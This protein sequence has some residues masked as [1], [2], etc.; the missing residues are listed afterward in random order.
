M[1]FL[2]ILGLLIVG[3]FFGRMRRNRLEN[4]GEGA[5]RRYLTT[6]FP[7]DDFHLMNNLTLPYGDGTTQID[8]VLVSRYGVFVVETKHW[9]GW[10]FA[11]A[12]AAKWTQVKFKAKR[13]F[14]NP[15][16][17]NH[18]HVLAVRALLDFVRAE[19][20]HSVVV[21][22]GDAVFKTNKPPGV[23][24]CRE[25][26]GHIFGFLQEVLTRDQMHTAVGRLECAR[27]LVSG[28]TDAEHVA[29][30]NRRFGEL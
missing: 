4:V 26:Q 28:Q 3:F 13:Q 6:E 7:E 2:K 17:Q 9:S 16:R 23:F 21:F 15:I 10:L 19:H 1:L 11:N 24:T 12:N 22:T 14:Q 8:H 27:R 30:L 25:M 29:Y 5:V 18:K 20:V